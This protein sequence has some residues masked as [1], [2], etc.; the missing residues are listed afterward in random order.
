MIRPPADFT[1]RVLEVVDAIPAARV[2]TYGDVAG[3]LGSRASRV[4][5]RVMAGYGSDVAWWRVVRASGH[6]ALGHEG[7]ALEHFRAEGTPL[8]PSPTGYRVDL[9]LARWSPLS[10]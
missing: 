10:R 7:S 8:L 9:R 1:A 6:P 5:G 2:M 3:V 4:V